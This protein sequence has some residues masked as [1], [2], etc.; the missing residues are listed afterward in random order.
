[1]LAMSYSVVRIV[2]AILTPVNH[3]LCT[4]IKLYTLK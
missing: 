2:F 4:V 3:G 1:M